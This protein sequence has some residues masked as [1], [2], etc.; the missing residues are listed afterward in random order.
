MQLGGYQL[1]HWQRTIPYINTNIDL[2]HLMV[3]IAV[4]LQKISSMILEHAG[5]IQRIFAL[6][7]FKYIRWLLLD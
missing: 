5:K 7:E 1:R 3:L 4:K 6:V 2:S